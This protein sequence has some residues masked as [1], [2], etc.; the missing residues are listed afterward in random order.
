MAL[1]SAIGAAEADLQEVPAD[2]PVEQVARRCRS[3]YLD[4]CNLSERRDGPRDEVGRPDRPADLLGV[5][6]QPHRRDA[7]ELT[8]AVVR[9]VAGVPR[10]VTGGRGVAL[11]VFRAV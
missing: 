3:G 5:Q 1:C 8:A 9:A 7:E 10:D 4:L 2:H 11:T 6:P